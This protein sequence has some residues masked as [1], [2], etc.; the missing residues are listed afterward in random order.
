MCKHDWV[1]IPT[2]ERYTGSEDHPGVHKYTKYCEKCRK[3]KKKLKYFHS[4][5]K[6]VDLG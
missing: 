1:W 2:I 3:M 4:R 6:K 5:W